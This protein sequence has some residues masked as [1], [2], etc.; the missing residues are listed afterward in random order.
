MFRGEEKKK[1]R[2]R[3]TASSG[4]SGAGAH[5]GTIVLRRSLETDCSVRGFFLRP[6]HRSVSLLYPRALG[7]CGLELSH[8]HLFGRFNFAPPPP[9]PHSRTQAR[10]SRH[11][12]QKKKERKGTQPAARA[13]RPRSNKNRGGSGTAATTRAKRMSRR[14]R[15]RQPPRAYRAGVPFDHF[16]S[17]SSTTLQPALP[18]QS[19]YRPRLAQA[20]R[21]R[22]QCGSE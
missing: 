6:H 10:K 19:Y 20:P 12:A 11:L 17:S 15:T 16:R 13:T 18:H 8:R 7:K 5:K 2:P 22:P 3:I 9:R 21:R 4:E 14:K 1:N